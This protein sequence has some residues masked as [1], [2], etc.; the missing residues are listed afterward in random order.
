MIKIKKPKT[1]SILNSYKSGFR[2]YGKHVN[3][4]IMEMNKKKNNHNDNNKFRGMKKKGE[5]KMKFVY[6]NKHD[7]NIRYHNYEFPSRNRDL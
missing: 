4:I 7:H 2:C 6:I 3:I 1:I 5:R